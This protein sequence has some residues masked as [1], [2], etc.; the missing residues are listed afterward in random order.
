[1]TGDVTLRAVTD[2]DLP[3]FFEQERDTESRHMAAF[4]SRDG[5]DRDAFMAHWARVRGEDSSVTRTILYDEQVAGSVGSWLEPGDSTEAQRH[6]GYWLGKAYW[7]KGIATRALTLYLRELPTRPLYAHA[8]KDN[9]GSIRVLE[10]CGFTLLSEDM[11][12]SQA[13]GAEIPEVLMRLDT[14]APGTATPRE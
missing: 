10:K 2:S 9:H 13:R 5:D 6:L 11:Y 14:T 1:M 12:F 7:G 3:I 4:T 8:A